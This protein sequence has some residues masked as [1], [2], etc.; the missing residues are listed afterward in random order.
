MKKL[1]FLTAALVA[2][3][4]M[5]AQTISI[6]GDNADWAE[7]P[8]LSDPGTM[9]VYKAIVPQEGLTLPDD[10]A[11]CVMVQRTEEQKAIYPGAPVSYVDAD[12]DA[13]TTAAGEAWY[14]PSFGPDYEMGAWDGNDGASSEDETIDEVVIVKSKFDAGIP[15]DGSCHMWMLFNWSKYLPNSPEENNWNWAETSYHPVIVKPYTFADLNGT[16]AAADVYSTHSALTPGESLDM[17][18][19]GS[20]VDV[21]LWASWAVTLSEPAIY[22]IKADITSTNAASVDLQLVNMA[23]NAVVASFASEALEAGQDVT[24]GVWNLSAVPAGKYMLRFSNHVEFSAM[25]LNSLTFATNDSHSVVNTAAEAKVTKL[26]RNGQ[27]VIMRND[28][29]FNALGAEMK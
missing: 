11:L 6:D 17:M 24:A 22:T 16:L 8:M 13:T 12:R 28:K 7:V 23:T 15:F 18:V 20:A 19:A 4:T 5:N 1:F 2:A 21:Q 9:P 3:C 27:V 26:I 25:K 29:C 10:A 14:C